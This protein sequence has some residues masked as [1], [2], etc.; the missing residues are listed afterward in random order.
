MLPAPMAAVNPLSMV[1]L[2]LTLASLVG[3]FFYIQL[4]GWL[5]D[6]EALRTKITL[7]KFGKTEDRDKA[8][9]ECRVEQAR[10]AAWHTLVV[11]VAVIWFVWFVLQAGFQM[12]EMS[13]TDPLYFQVH[14]T[15]VVFERLF[16]ILSI[17]LFA[18]GLGLSAW[19]WWE[20]KKLTSS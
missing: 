20:L 10:L 11:N 19:N 3:S 8:I 18:L 5:R 1:G 7:N 6:V 17:G 16:L 15:F 4:S 2:M 12:I 13:R 14:Y 9:R